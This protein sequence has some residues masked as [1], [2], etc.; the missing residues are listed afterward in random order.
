MD[1]L[2]LRLLL[3]ARDEG[4]LA[5]AADREH[6]AISAVS[7]RISVFE[8]RY[9]VRLLDRHDRGVS[10]TPEGA[11]ILDRIAAALE[12]LEQIA[13]DLQEVKAG[14]RGHVR[15]RAHTTAMLSG[16]LAQRLADFLQQYPDVEVELDEGTSLDIVHAIR[17]GVCDLGLISG[18][19]ESQGIELIPWM[20]DQ[21]VAVL[22]VD[23]RLAAKPR[24][25]LTDLVSEP[26]IGMQRDSSLLALYRTQAAASGQTLVERVH[27]ASFESVRSMIAAGLGVGILPAVACVP[28]D[29]DRLTYR[30]LDEPWAHRPLMLCMRDRH[31]L[32]AAAK[33]LAAHLRTV[34]EDE[35]AA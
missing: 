33:L 6:I 11:P 20:E 4:N 19:V 16:S 27:A 26:F 29:G 22:P 8:N 10:V 14:V 31:A 21:L 23:H 13:R 35:R 3:A 9:G 25:S 28:A 18:T 2:T 5:R 30:Q 7:R 15:L 32:A 17:V 1:L 12:L 34:G 24:L